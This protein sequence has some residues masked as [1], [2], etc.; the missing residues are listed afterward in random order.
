MRLIFSPSSALRVYVRFPLQ[1][2]QLMHDISSHASS[3]H[4]EMRID[5]FDSISATAHQHVILQSIKVTASQLRNRVFCATH[6]VWQIPLA[7]VISLLSLT[8][9]LSQALCVCGRFVGALLWEGV[10]G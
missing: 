5:L 4:V 2:R 3:N 6:A 7:Y 9:R 1:P 10:H 8:R